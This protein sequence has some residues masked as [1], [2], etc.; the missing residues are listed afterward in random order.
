MRLGVHVSIAGGLL[1]AL[2]RARELGCNTMQIFS[3]SPRGGAASPLTK[4]DVKRFHAGRQASGIDPLIVHAPYI[5]N[6]ASPTRRTW[7]F[8]VRWYQEE[9]A[10][11]HALAAAYLVTHV[12]SH[13][14]SGE[15]AGITRVASAINRTL[16]SL[17]SPVMIALENTAGSGQ[18]LGYSFEQLAAMRDR[19]TDKA[20]V[21]IC[22]DTAHLFASGFAIH[23]EEGLEA[24]LT[25]FDQIIGLEHLKV[26]HLNDSKAAFKS[27][28]DRHWH[29]GEGRIGLDAMRRIVTHP[30]LQQV[31]FILETPKKT[32]QDD[33]RN[34]ATVRR[35]VT[36]ALSPTKGPHHAGIA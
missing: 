6:L 28:V 26:I 31:P 11:C 34:L 27:R 3:R 30:S 7:S 25:R 4:K 23:T 22:L 13:R 21:G 29:I 16:E 17:A 1:S 14:G 2:E 33:P 32:P 9:Y 19:V 15:N 24:T 8:S 20:R 36:A 5:I 18:G 10:R 12:G 35:L